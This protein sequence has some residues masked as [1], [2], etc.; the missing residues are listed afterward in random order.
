MEV[1][2][3]G[4]SYNQSIKR[5]G[6]NPVENEKVLFIRFGVLCYGFFATLPLFVESR[7]DLS[8][9]RISS[10]AFFTVP[11]TRRTVIIHSRPP[12]FLINVNAAQTMR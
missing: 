6:F 12:N 3:N 8:R 2:L 1:F 7:A 5:I 4:T 10:S 11:D 9:R